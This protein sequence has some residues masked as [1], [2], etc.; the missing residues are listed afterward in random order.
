MCNSF[1]TV[2]IQWGRR[3]GQRSQRQLLCDKSICLLIRSKVGESSFVFC[4]RTGQKHRG[5]DCVRQAIVIRCQK[6]GI[7]ALGHKTHRSER[8]DRTQAQAHTGTLPQSSA[9]WEGQR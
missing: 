5:V 7:R 3:D 9:K 2:L 4:M 1:Q 6:V 8:E